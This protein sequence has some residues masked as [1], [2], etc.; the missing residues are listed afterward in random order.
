MFC[1]QLGKS[2]LENI[3]VERMATDNAASSPV[4][5]DV[6]GEITE[7]IDTSDNPGGV[8][9][10]STSPPRS[11]TADQ[12]TTVDATAQEIAIVSSE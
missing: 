10:I 1:L 8:A 2:H 7:S 4:H 12:A 5:G 6:H 3:L 9:T 11:P